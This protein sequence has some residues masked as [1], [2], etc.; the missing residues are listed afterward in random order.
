MN[1]EEKIQS[2]LDLDENWNSYTDRKKKLLKKACKNE[3]RLKRYREKLEQKQKKI[4][5]EAQKKLTQDYI[6]ESRHLCLKLTKVFFK[7]GFNAKHFPLVKFK[8]DLKQYWQCVGTYSN[9]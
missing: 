1:D 6:E 7:L 3:N 9:K 2:L 5:N 4:D 8:D